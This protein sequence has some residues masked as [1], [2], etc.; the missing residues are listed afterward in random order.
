MN[1][2][3]NI[4]EQVICFQGPATLAPVPNKVIGERWPHLIMHSL[5]LDSFQVFEKPGGKSS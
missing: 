2:P 5:D 3:T 4:K 1:H